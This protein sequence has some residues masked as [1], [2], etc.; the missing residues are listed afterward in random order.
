MRGGWD[1]VNPNPGVPWF[2]SPASGWS[3][4][5]SVVPKF[6]EYARTSGRGRFVKYWSY[7]RVGD[8][9]AVEWGKV[10]TPYPDWH[11]MVVTDIV[12]VPGESSFDIRFTYHTTNRKDKSLRALMDDNPN[13]KW[14]GFHVY[15]ASYARSTYG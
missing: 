7:I 13:A 9:V 1:F 3:N 8:V 2:Y 5:W 14:F 12:G 10:S 15:G 4:S 11:S 6:M